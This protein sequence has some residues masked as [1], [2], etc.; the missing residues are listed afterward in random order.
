[1][2]IS[3]K[4]IVNLVLLCVS[5]MLFAGCGGGG[6][7]SPAPTTGSLK[8]DNS[9]A[10]VPIHELYVSLSTSPTW[11]AIRNTSTIAGGSS[12]T[13]S[14]LAAGTYDAKIAS[15]AA[16]SSYYAYAY[17]FPITVGNTYTLT[18]TNTSYTGSL[19]INNTN[20]TYPITALYVSTTCLGCGTNQITTSIA[21]GATRQ[22][23]NIPAGTYFVRAVQNGLNRDNSGVGIASYSY[24]TITYN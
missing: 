6:D 22:L 4:G 23:V 18:A 5:A 13:L 21:P 11:G 7:S 19:I 24:T 14:G 2:R 16:V 15:N 8:I 20:P 1:M 17:G 3:I 10:T 12:W 9:A